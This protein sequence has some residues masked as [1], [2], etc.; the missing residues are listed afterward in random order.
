LDLKR[1]PNQADACRPVHWRRRVLAKCQCRHPCAGQINEG[2]WI[3]QTFAADSGLGRGWSDI[4]KNPN[5]A[6]AAASRA[7]HSSDS[8]LAISVR[9]RSPFRPVQSCSSRP[10]RRRRRRGPPGQ[11]QGSPEGDP[12]GH[13]SAD[14]HELDA[15]KRQRAH[16]NQKTTVTGVCTRCLAVRTGSTD[17]HAETRA[18]DRATQKNKDT[19]KHKVTRRGD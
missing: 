8:Q 10:P 4:L 2:S 17:D 6:G 7:P 3:E 16:D 9:G 14:M 15:A 11:P 1:F 13:P 12:T 5:Q 19:N 18:T